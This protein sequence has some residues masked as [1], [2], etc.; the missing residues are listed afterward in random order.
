M[1]LREI[2]NVLSHVDL[3]DIALDLPYSSEDNRTIG[4]LVDY[5]ICC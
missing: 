1:R 5:R 2:S 3:K 4:G